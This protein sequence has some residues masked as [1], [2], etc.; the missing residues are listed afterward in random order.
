MPRTSASTYVGSSCAYVRGNPGARAFC[1][2]LCKETDE[3]VGIDE[4]GKCVCTGFNEAEHVPGRQDG[5]GIRERRSCN[6]REEKVS[7]RLQATK[8]KKGIK[9][10]MTKVT[11]R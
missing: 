5:E 2:R 6:L 7:T 10:Q 9:A 4:F 8:T 3:L 1:H 11:C